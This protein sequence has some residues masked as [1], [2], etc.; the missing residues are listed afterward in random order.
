MPDS[1]HNDL[2]F[3]CDSALAGAHLVSARYGQHRFEK[4]FHDELVIAI[5]E[6]GVGTCRTRSCREASGPGSV[7]IFAPGEYH[8]GEIDNRWNYRAIYLDQ[9]GLQALASILS[10]ESSNRLWIAPGLYRDEQLAR[11]LLRAHQCFDVK[12]SI[13]ERQT[14]WWAAMG[15]L[16]GRYG[17]PRPQTGM[18]NPGR[19]NLEKAREY[20]ECNLSRNISIDELASVCGLTRFHLIRSFSREFGL[21]PH[22]YASQLRLLAAKQLISA[23]EKPVNAAVSV[24]FY[25]QSH[26]SK[27]FTRAYGLTPGAYSR[28]RGQSLSQTASI[29]RL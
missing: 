7:W 10:H 6:E 15:M 1:A 26:L 20:L 14:R 8:C 25:D 16:F 28:L 3:W 17:E 12:T 22:A 9:Q 11:L 27:L 23:G 29:P 21:P 13:M 4:H 5:T 19:K 24:G 18:R 2:R